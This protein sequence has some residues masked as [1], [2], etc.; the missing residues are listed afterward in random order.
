MTL[1]HYL[2]FLKYQEECIPQHHFAPSPVTDTILEKNCTLEEFIIAL[3]KVLV[4]SLTYKQWTT[5]NLEQNM[6][7][8]TKQCSFFQNS[9]SRSSLTKVLHLYLIP[10]SAWVFS[11][12]NLWHNFGTPFY[13]NTSGWL[14]LVFL[15]FKFIKWVG[16]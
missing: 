16:L 7:A 3:L 5:L 6:E 11:P 8:F 15:N 1:P 10:I 2:R 13:K 4:V 12:V 9:C 14:L